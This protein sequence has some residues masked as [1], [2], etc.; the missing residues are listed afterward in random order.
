MTPQKSASSP[1]L[2]FWALL[3]LAIALGV[4]LRWFWLDYKFFWEDEVST[5][6]RMAG[7]NP[8]TLA[9]QF[10]PPQLTTV[11]DLLAYQF[12]RSDR[13]LGAVLTNLRTEGTIHTPLYFVLTYLW[14]RLGMIGAEPSIALTRSFSTVVSL[15][16]LPCFY[17]L[18][19]A[20]FRCRLTALVAVALMASSPFHALY[21]QEARPYSLYLLLTVLSGWAL[22]VACR[23]NRPWLWGVYGLTVMAGLYSFL[24]YTLVL[25]AHT[26]YGCLGW[27]D[28]AVF[29]RFATATLA[30]TLALV[31]WLV[32][33]W[34]QGQTIARNTRW[35][36]ESIGLTPLERLHLLSLN[37]T[38]P[39]LDLDWPA[40][41]SLGRWWPYGLAVVAVVALVIYSL[42]YMVRHAPRPAGLYG[43]LLV[44]GPGLLLA[45]LDWGVDGSM[46]Q[47]TRYFAPAYIGCELAVAY[48]L[49]HQLRRS[50]QG[51]W[52]WLT[53]AIVTLGIVSIGQQVLAPVWWNKNNGYIYAAAQVINQAPQPLVLGG[54]VRL[55][56]AL[57]HHLNPDTALVAFVGGD[58]LPQLPPGYSDYFLHQVSGEWAQRYGAAT[59]YR[60]EPLGDVPIWRIQP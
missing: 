2:L 42:V 6:L 45:G 4:G 40:G 41:F 53:V 59:G 34:P 5:A 19:L 37:L 7:Y 52:P 27:R 38:R 15:V 39:F 44:L 18:A 31:P 29:R 36:T 17:G 55:T 10:D 25:L 30:G 14:V 46:A 3:V 58:A 12:P 26:A 33:V 1:A 11:G 49:G 28:G 23:R 43:L 48:W 47:I 60:L 8:L 16:T 9:A 22:V 35:Q 57:A 20:L 50:P 13:P 54:D 56:L 32:A 24:L 51:L 21:A